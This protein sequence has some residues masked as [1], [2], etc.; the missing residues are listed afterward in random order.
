METWLLSARRSVCVVSI[1]PHQQVSPGKK[2]KKK[3]KNEGKTK[4]DL[5]NSLT[6]KTVTKAR[7]RVRR[8]RTTKPHSKWKPSAGGD[9]ASPPVSASQQL[10]EPRLCCSGR[11]CRV[12]PGAFLPLLLLSSHSKGCLLPRCLN[13]P[14]PLAQPPLPPH[15]EPF[16]CLVEGRFLVVSWTLS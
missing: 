15:R 16:I 4:K 14:A 3:T 6:G 12:F 10:S 9:P 7:L 11:L 5:W 8:D 2:R 13:C 1:G